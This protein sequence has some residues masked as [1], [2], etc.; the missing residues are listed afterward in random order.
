MIR[1]LRRRFIRIALIALTAAMVAVTGIVNAA[2]WISVRGELVG[3][4]TLL[5]ENSAMNR[6]DM[7]T[8]MAGK[9]RH[10]RSLVGESRWFSVFL[11]EDGEVRNVN[12]AGMTDLDEEAAKSLALQAAERSGTG[13]AFLQ[14]Y[15]F[16]VRDGDRGGRIVWLLDCET[17][18]AAVRKL[19]LISDRKSVV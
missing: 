4:L 11:N 16:I 7:G 3:T 1:K 9:S 14:D 2:N 10:T 12:L 8:R 6:A 15:L 13:A 17:R 19:A 5:T 18:L